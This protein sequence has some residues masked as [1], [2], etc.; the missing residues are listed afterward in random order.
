MLAT[1]HSSHVSYTSTCIRARALW[2]QAM[3]SMAV[4][5]NPQ[6]QPKDRPQH[7][8][9]E[10]R[11]KSATRAINAMNK[12]RG[13]DPMFFSGDLKVRVHDKRVRYTTC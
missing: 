6:M 9:T 11:I 7:E 12:I 3:F 10:V 1:T 2:C 13:L 4:L 5:K 8:K